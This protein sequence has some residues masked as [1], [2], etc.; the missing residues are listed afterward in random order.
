M[1]GESAL[2]I[3]LF[4]FLLLK[5][6]CRWRWREKS[7]ASFSS[8]LSS[9]VSSLRIVFSFLFTFT[10]ASGHSLP[11]SLACSARFRCFMLDVM[12]I[13]SHQQVTGMHTEKAHSI[14][15]THSCLSLRDQL[16]YLFVYFTRKSQVQALPANSHKKSNY[17]DCVC[18]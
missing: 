3:F 12:C 9:L 2:F 6:A 18:I 17:A 11:P 10:W 8:S 16:W 1:S 4:L 5:G 13:F 14:F 7:G 15:L